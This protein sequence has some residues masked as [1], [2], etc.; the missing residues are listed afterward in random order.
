ME[1]GTLNAV[2]TDINGQY[3]LKLTT[4]DPTLEI[5]INNWGLDE[6]GMILTDGKNTL[7]IP[8]KIIRYP[9]AI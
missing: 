6:E 1:K 9:F 2:I 4:A 8:S 5:N 3:N 7:A